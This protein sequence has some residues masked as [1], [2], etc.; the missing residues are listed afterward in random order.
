M[1]QKNKD[2]SKISC[3]DVFFQSV[4]AEKRASETDS[5]DDKTE[6]IKN[7][8]PEKMSKLDGFDPLSQSRN[9]SS[10]V[11]SSSGGI[12]TDMG[13]PKKYMGSQT[14]NSIWDVNNI[15]KLIKIKDNKEKTIDEQNNIKDFKV[16]AKEDRI[17][18][19][20][21][22]LESVDLRKQ[23]VIKSIET[24]SLTNYKNLKGNISI[25]DV[26]DYERVPEKTEGEQLSDK[27]AEQKKKNDSWEDNQRAMSSKKIVSKLFDT[28][29]GD[30]K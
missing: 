25:F 9:P 12:Q 4:E 29:L 16:K 1:L 27:L 2:S 11:I 5:V 7:I 18:A 13:G 28:L 22:D 17:N 26:G 21:E 20:I 3:L 19:M 30:E 24:E 10:S 6:E 23:S 15:E 8:Q 14:N